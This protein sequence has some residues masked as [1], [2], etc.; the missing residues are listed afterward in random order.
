MHHLPL[1][2]RNRTL[3]SYHILIKIYNKQIKIYHKLIKTCH[4]LDKIR[5][6]PTNLN[7]NQPICIQYNPL[8]R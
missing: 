1:W 5:H 6:Q 8:W 2:I 7:Q 3:Q 4:K